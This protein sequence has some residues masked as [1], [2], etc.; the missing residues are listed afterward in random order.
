MAGAASTGTAVKRPFWMHQIVEYILGICLVASG[1]QSPTPVMPSILGGVLLVYAASTRSAVAAFRLLPRR[2]HRVGDPALVGVILVGAL[3]PW[4]EVDLGTR[5]IIGGVAVVYLVVWSQSSYTERVPRSAR[6]A[7][8]ADGG[9]ASPNPGGSTG[10]TSDTATE[11]G[12]RLGRVVAGGI[13]AARRVR[14]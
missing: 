10:T 9:A 12:R 11:V 5:F 6:V 2:I 8:S 1:T 7:T 13:S 14:R 4:I 3:Q